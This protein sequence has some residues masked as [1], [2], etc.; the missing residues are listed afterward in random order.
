MDACSRWAGVHNKGPNDGGKGLYPLHWSLLPIKDIITSQE[1][2]QYSKI[3]STKA[4]SKKGR[5]V[6]PLK[7]G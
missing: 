7:Q 4:K 1:R 6:Y 3:P 2:D 5:K